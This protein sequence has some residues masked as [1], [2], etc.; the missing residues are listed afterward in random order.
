M[1]ILSLLGLNLDQLLVEVIAVSCQFVF[2]FLGFLLK[3]L[4][5][6]CQVFHLGAQ[7]LILLFLL[8][9]LFLC[10]SGLLLTL[11]HPLSLVLSEVQIR[12]PL[13][14]HVIN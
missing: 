3:I 7:V 14:H 2:L 6:V 13:L 4:Q 1:L 8:D 10:L 12:S 5:L 11:V 9:E